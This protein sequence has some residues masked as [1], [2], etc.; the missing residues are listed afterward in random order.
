LPGFTSSPA[1]LSRGLGKKLDHLPAEGRNVIRLTAGDQIP[2]DHNLFID[3]FGPG[4]AEVRLERRPRGD[5]PALC[6][7]SIEGSL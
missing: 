4:I 7:A 3:P 6:T 2:V 5:P 1:R